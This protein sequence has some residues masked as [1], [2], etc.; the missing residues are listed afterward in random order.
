M[1]FD[2]KQAKI[3]EKIPALLY[4]SFSALELLRT[5]RYGS[6]KS[7][8]LDTAPPEPSQFEAA[9]VSLGKNCPKLQSD[10][11]QHFFNKMKI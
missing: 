5:E 3:P 8:L 2:G 10:L 9:Y 7:F 4:C 1:S 6:K 11:Q